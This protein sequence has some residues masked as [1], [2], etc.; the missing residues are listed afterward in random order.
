MERCSPESD[1]ALCLEILVLKQTLAKR[2]PQHWTAT[3]LLL[4]NASA[5]IEGFAFFE[6]DL[7]RDRS[8]HSLSTEAGA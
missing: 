4:D 7:G 5:L 1:S 2:C 6:P 3:T 8:S